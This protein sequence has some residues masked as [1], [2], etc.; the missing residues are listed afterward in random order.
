MA[1]Q[2]KY[3]GEELEARIDQIPNKVDKEAGKG[4]SSN[5]FTNAYKQKLDN[6]VQTIEQVAVAAIDS[7]VD[8]KIAKAVDVKE[9]AQLVIKEFDAPDDGGLY[10]RSG[11]KWV[12]IKC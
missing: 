2:I 9:I 4:L 8:E 1:Y 10:A 7:L 12:E 3:S 6:L 5:D 11:G